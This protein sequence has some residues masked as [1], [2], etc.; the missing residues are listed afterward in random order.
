MLCDGSAWHRLLALL[1]LGHR[2]EV[3]E[4]GGGQVQQRWLVDQIAQC[5]QHF[6]GHCREVVVGDE[7]VPAVR[8]L[9]Q[10]VAEE[11]D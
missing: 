10:V 3:F 2:F 9:E 6:W 7:L 8:T 1:Y 5:F 4:L 11:L